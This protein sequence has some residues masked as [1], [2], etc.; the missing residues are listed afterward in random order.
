MAALKSLLDKSN[1]SVILRLTSVDWLFSFNLIWFLIWQVTFN[2]NL[3]IFILCYETQS[4]LNLLFKLF[5]LSNKTSLT[6]L[7][8]CLGGEKGSDTAL[9]QPGGDRSPDDSPGLH[10][11]PRSRASSLLLHRGVS[12]SFL[13]GLHWHPSWGGLITV[14]HLWLMVT[15]LTTLY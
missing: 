7:W 1:I 10:W 12:S 5:W 13:C 2:W 8:R 4:C 11:Y 9:L 14:S 3:D 15:V 6:M